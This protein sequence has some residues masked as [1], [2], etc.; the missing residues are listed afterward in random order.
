M[1]PSGSH[2][3]GTSTIVDFPVGLG[4]SEGLLFSTNALYFPLIR[5]SA[6]ISEIFPVGS[7]TVSVSLPLDPLTDSTVS[8]VPLASII[9]GL[10]DGS[11]F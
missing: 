1:Y 6:V 2:E 4:A 7:F 3:T 8:T 10:Y 9:S 11:A 5:S